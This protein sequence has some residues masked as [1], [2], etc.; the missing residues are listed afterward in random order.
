VTGEGSAGLRP[1]IDYRL[2]PAVTND[3]L[4][5]LFA[6]AWAG[7]RSRD[8]TPVLSRSLCYLC[9][10]DEDALVGFVNI[11]WDG[12]VHGFLLDTTVAPAW[13]RQGIGRELVIRSIAAASAQDIEWLHVDYEPHLAAFY[14]GCGFRSTLAGL[15]KLR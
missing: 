8:F 11:A 13:Q 5:A 3:R 6:A 12:G 2:N 9:A 7:H 1:L 4:N 15:I 10:L 14:Q